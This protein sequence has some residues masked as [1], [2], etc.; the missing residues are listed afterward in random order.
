[1]TSTSVRPFFDIVSVQ[2][3]EHLDKLWD[4]ALYSKNSSFNNVNNPKKPSSSYF[5]V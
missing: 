2:Q 1:M 5:R 3:Q 4:E